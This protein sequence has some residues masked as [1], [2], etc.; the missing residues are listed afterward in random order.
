MNLKYLFTMSTAAL[1][2]SSFAQV[3]GTFSL[4]QSDLV[5]LSFANGFVGLSHDNFTPDAIYNIQPYSF[6]GFCTDLQIPAYWNTLYMGDTR[7]T[8]QDFYLLNQAPTV[9]AQ[10]GSEISWIA[11]H[12]GFT[13]NDDT[14]GEAQLAI[15]EVEGSSLLDVQTYLGGAF[16]TADANAAAGMVTAAQNGYAGGVRSVSP[17]YESPFTAN[18]YPNQVTQNFVQPMATPESPSQIVVAMGLIGIFLRRRA[19]RKD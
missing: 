3:T 15:W 13:T 4:D 18:D 10:I 17:W 1:A 11:N 8:T 2:V 12:Y 7:V 6:E 5:G 16:T 9:S 19:V 14:A